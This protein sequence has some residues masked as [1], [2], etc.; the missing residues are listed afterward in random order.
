VI[1]EP[2]E[3]LKIAADPRNAKA[4][5]PANEEQIPFHVDA[6][7]W[8]FEMLSALWSLLAE[9]KKVID[10]LWEQSVYVFL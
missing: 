7:H 8:P 10:D 6:R 2:C 9:N 3:K 5:T 1:N 4:K